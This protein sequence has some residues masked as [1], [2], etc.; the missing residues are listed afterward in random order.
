MHKR[1]GILGGMS[2]ESTIEYYRYITRRYTER[3]GDYAYPEILIY[4]VSFQRYVDWPNQERWDLVA[5][6][7]AEGARRLEA[8][9]ADLI[10]IATNTM[11]IVFDQVRNSVSVPMLSLLDAVGDAA[12]EMGLG[13]VGLLGTRFTMEKTFYQ[14]ALAARGIRVLVPDETDRAY[15]NRVIYDELVAGQIREES[16]A[17]F[18]QIINRLAD[19]GAGGIVL[20]CTEI[21]LLVGEDDVGL[22]LLDTT[23][24]HA[25]AALKAALHWTPEDSA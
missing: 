14:D 12:T 16:R 7:L 4:S 5:Q 10:L 13:T 24:I 1:I 19:R 6:G 8:A 15:V 23:L 2:P 20:G 9:G 21:P 17:G 18:V 25:E 11:H 22:P 3:Y